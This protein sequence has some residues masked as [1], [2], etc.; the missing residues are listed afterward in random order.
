MITKLNE[1]IKINENL[2]VPRNLENRLDKLKQMNYKLLQQEVIEGYLDI[3]SSFEF[4]FD[5]ITIKTKEI[6]GNVKIHLNYIPEWFENIKING[7]FFNDG[8]ILTSLKGCPKYVKYSFICADNNLTSLEFGP[9]YV[10]GNFYCSDNNLTSLEFCPK[11]V[12][13]DFYCS[14][15]KVQFTEEY[16]RSLCNVQGNIYI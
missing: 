5:N 14:D 8:N 16:V 6:N 15:N 3:D 12:G 1:F 11:Y 4:N 10:G 7:T 2:F 9:E 13:G